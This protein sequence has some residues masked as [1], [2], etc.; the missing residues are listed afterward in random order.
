MTPIL[1]LVYHQLFPHL[2]CHN[3][4][5]V[6]TVN[7][8]RK[9]CSTYN[10]REDINGASFNC[11]QQALTLPMLHPINR[12]LKLS[13][14]NNNSKIMAEKKGKKKER[15]LIEARVIGS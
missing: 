14:S 11:I 1:L 12:D 6:H 10:I 3:F 2:K 15:N 5:N 8:Y 13:L 7:R 4:Q 9:G